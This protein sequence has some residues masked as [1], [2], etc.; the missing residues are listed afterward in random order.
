M[1]FWGTPV[2]A[3]LYA[4]LSY[5]PP[6][7]AL[8]LFK[9]QNT[10][11][12]Y[13]ALWLLYIHNRQFVDPTPVAQ[14]K[15]AALFAF[16]S[17]LYQP[18]WTVYRVGGQMTPTTLLLFALGLLSYTQQRLWI[19]MGALI[20]ATLIKPTLSIALFFLMLVSGGQ[21]FGITLALLAGVSLLSLLSMGWS[22]HVEFLTVLLHGFR[23]SFPWF[24]NSSLYVPLEN[25]RLLS[26]V[27]S[28]GAV[29]DVVC[30]V[31][32]TSIKIGVLA[33]FVY[34]MRQRSVLREAHRARR[35]FNFL[36][37]VACSLL[38]PQTIWE[39]Y[40]AL[41]F[42][43]LAYVVASSRH[44]SR[45]ARLIIAGIFVLSLGQNLIVVNMLREY[46]RFDSLPLLLM[47]GLFKSGPLWL[48]LLLLWRHHKAWLHSYAAPQW[49][50]A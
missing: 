9:I 11:A 14:A 50:R 6:H 3:W 20:L 8:V 40:L 21:C 15:F 47:I 36:M 12:C 35:H 28:S 48:T 5:V 24:Y 1:A 25:V 49:M 37:A 23:S 18:L 45:E 22:L 29:R 34:L 7:W 43:C 31:I 10:L 13:A 33:T 2:S 42:V 17:L 16:L 4:P 38:L 27:G 41:L 44:F 46:L 32:E 26:E 30:G 19:A 39:H